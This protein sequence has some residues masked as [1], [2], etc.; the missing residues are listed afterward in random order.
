M[1]GYVDHAW[2]HAPKAA[3]GT[4]PIPGLSSGEELSYGT[5]IYIPVKE[6]WTADNQVTASGGANSYAANNWTID[7]TYPGGGYC[8]DTVDGHAISF[9]FK[10][11]PRNSIWGF[12]PLL[13]RGT[14][15][16]I[17][18]FDITSVLP[19]TANPVNSSADPEGDPETGNEVWVTWDTIDCYA[20]ADNPY[21]TVSSIKR[22]RI[23]GAVGVAGTSATV[24]GTDNARQWDGGPG[25]HRIRAYTNG[26]N[27]SSSGYR[28]RLGGLVIVRLDDSYLP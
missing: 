15:Y 17:V 16:G 26:K 10:M 5:P 14:D 3:G 11:G 24:S 1:S 23:N 2:R 13:S 28:V 27:A 8:M 25:Y 21:H 18:D 4:D 22:L 19:L 7:A 9:L 6:V 12:L 20:A